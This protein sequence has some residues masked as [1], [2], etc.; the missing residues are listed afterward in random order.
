MYART[1]AP[2]GPD[3]ALS[4]SNLGAYPASGRRVGFHSITSRLWTPPGHSPQTAVSKASRRAPIRLFHRHPG[5]QLACDQ[6]HRFGRRS[7]AHL[8]KVVRAVPTRPATARRAYRLCKRRV[9]SSRSGPRLRACALADNS[10][11]ARRP[12]CQ[13]AQGERSRR[14]HKHERGGPNAF[15]VAHTQMRNN[16]TQEVEN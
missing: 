3:H 11:R 4:G 14:D 15:D 1:E 16:R 10:A 2:L 7:C 8:S 5:G 13:D 6:L 9:S 12:R